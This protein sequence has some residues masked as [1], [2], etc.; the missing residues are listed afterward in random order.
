MFSRSH[1]TVLT[2]QT[3][4]AQCCRILGSLTRASTDAALGARAGELLFGTITDLRAFELGRR[5]QNLERELALQGRNIGRVQ[6]QAEEG[7]A[8]FRT[9]DWGTGV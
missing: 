5:T 8:Y 4:L 7:A 2:R 1:I 6:Q 9:C 3:D